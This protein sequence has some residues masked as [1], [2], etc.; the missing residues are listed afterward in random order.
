MLFAALGLAPNIKPIILQMLALF[1]QERRF[2][3]DRLGIEIFAL[4][5]CRAMKSG[6]T[7]S[8]TLSDS[9]A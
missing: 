7:A 8:V 4:P 2:F 6:R 5:Q 9:A 1:Y 3:S